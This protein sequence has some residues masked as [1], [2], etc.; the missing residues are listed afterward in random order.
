LENETTAPTTL[1]IGR[2]VIEVCK[3][4]GYLQTGKDK[5]DGKY[6]AVSYD[7]LIGGIRK[8]LVDAGIVI[9]PQLTSGATVATGKT[10]S[11]GT[12]IIRYEGVF[13]VVFMNSDDK[14]DRFTV[15]VPVHAEDT[16]DK[17]PGKAIT[18]AVKSAI[19]KMFQVESGDEEESRIQGVPTNPLT[20]NERADELVKMNKATAETLAD[21]AKAS[22]TLAKDRGD[23][24]AYEDFRAHAH[25]LHQQLRKA[26]VID[27]PTATDTPPAK[28]DATPPVQDA[29]GAQEP[30]DAAEPAESKRGPPAAPGLLKTLLAAI[31]D[32]E[33][34]KAKIL[35]KYDVASLDVL[36]KIEVKQAL[37]RVMELRKSAA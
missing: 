13:D 29:G 7:D 36:D 23:S 27:M 31:G 2:R 11:Q 5:I 4:Y 10:T 16:G 28:Q 22:L 15:V 35:K 34:M 3:Q 21:V 32:D 30:S 37:A 6:K 8:H 25:K 18:Y 1:G 24:E 26:P 20:A 33:P 9:Y 19:L 14:S 17:A 12:P